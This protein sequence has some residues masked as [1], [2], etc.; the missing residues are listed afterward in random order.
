MPT[1][2]NIKQKNNQNLINL[3]NKAKNF[4]GMKSCEMLRR[5]GNSTGQYKD[6]FNIRS[7]HDDFCFEILTSFLNHLKQESGSRWMSIKRKSV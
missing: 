6:W 2:Q 1:I 5:A 4:N 7:S 3:L